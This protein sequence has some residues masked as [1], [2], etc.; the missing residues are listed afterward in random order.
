MTPISL[1]AL[2]A[3]KLLVLVALW[4]FGSARTAVSSPPGALARVQSHNGD[5]GDLFGSAVALSRDGQVLVVGADDV[6]TQ[7]Y[8]TLGEIVDGLRVIESGLAVDDRVIVNGL[9]H[10]RPGAKVA[11][12]E[13]GASPQTSAP[14]ASGE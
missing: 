9:M 12:Q 1:R 8:V 4:S 7:K 2:I 3:L 5:G 13:E 6:A 11:P 10:A 14:L